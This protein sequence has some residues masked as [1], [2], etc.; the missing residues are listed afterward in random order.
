MVPIF[1]C[2]VR[3]LN[4]DRVV[5]LINLLLIKKNIL[6][7]FLYVLYFPIKFINENAEL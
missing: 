2:K 4:I 3:V 7:K 6:E 1:D 5:K